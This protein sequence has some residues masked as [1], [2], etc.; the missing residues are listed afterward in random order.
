MVEITKYKTATCISAAEKVTAYNAYDYTVI[1]IT[2][3]FSL[4]LSL[5]I[6]IYISYTHAQ[7]EIPPIRLSFYFSLFYFG[8][9]D[10]TSGLDFQCVRIIIVLHD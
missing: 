3:E 2:V 6:Y 5:Y 10:N 1:I 7:T 9:T 4:S 8:G